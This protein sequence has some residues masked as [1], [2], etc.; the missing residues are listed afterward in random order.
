MPRLSISEITTR[1]WSLA[2]DVQNYVAAGIEGIGVW[3]DKLDLFG[4]EEGLALLADSPLKVAN[5]VDAGYFLNK[6]RSQTRRAIEDVVEAIELAKR[7]R[8]D[9]LLIVTG[10]QGSFFRTVDQARRLIIT[11][12]KE[13][14]PVAEAARVR[15]GIEPVHPRYPCYTFLH[16]IPDT[17][18]VI[19]AVGSA[20]VGLF[21][22]TDHL[23]DSPSLLR[24]I[25]RAGGRIVGVHIN[26]R[27]PG[28]GTDCCIP[29]QG[30]LPLREILGAIE[31]AGYKGFY[32]VKILSEKVWATDYRQVLA[33]C[34]TGFERSWEQKK[35]GDERRCWGDICG[36]SE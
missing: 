21:F 29:G 17:L 27:P 9:T 7:L 19:E 10:G 4:P 23:D 5:L 25:E 31:A 28:P 15:L 13:L 1:N 8:T 3:R 33:E 32:D 34:K 11:A 12:L 14:A 2:E 26:D 16:T 6:T 36:V 20:N 18:E 35:A 30:V 22:D 24:D